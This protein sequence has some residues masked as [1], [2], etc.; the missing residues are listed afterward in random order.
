MVMS[1]D[2]AIDAD[3]FV[4]DFGEVFR[5]EVAEVSYL[6]HNSGNEPLAISIPVGTCPC[7]MPAVR[8][9]VIEFW[10]HHT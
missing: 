4:R 1:I 7:I 8:E 5:G 2:S 3:A 9:A 10:G 6:L